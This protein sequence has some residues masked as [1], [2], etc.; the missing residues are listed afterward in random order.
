MKTKKKQSLTMMQKMMLWFM[1][2]ILLPSCI[3]SAV[4]YQALT[5][6]AYELLVEENNAVM[7]IARESIHRSANSVES[8]VENISL[9]QELRRLLTDSRQTTYQRIA[10]ILYDVENTISRAKLMLSGLDARFT[11]FFADEQI[12][13]AYWTYLK[14]E[15]LED[16]PNYQHFLQMNTSSGWGGIGKLYPEETIIRETDNPTRLCYYQKILGTQG[17]C[18]G[19]VQCGISPEKI[20]LPLEIKD[21]SVFYVVQDGQVIYQADGV[22]PLP[23]EYRAE[24]TRQVIN[25]QL[26]LTRSLEGMGMQLVMRLDYG[27]LHSQALASGLVP[28]L[29]ALGS[30]ALLLIATCTFLHSIQK[31]L[32]QAVNFAQRAKEG[33]LEIA[34]P[35]PGED[36][37]GR[38]I[39][40]FNTLLERLQENS[41]R[42]IDHERKE[43]YA[44][45]LALQYQMNPHFLFNSL[46][47]IQLSAELGV[48]REQLSEAVLLLGKL[49]RNNLQGNA[50]TTLEEEVRCAQDYVR[51]MNMRKQDLVQLKLELD[52]LPPGLPVMRFLFQPL[53]ENAIQHGMEPG[54]PLQITIRGQQTGERVHLSV[55]NDG[56][57]I[58]LDKQALLQE[59]IRH[60]PDGRGIGLANLSARLRLLY[61]SDAEMTFTSAAERTRI[62]LYFPPQ[63][64]EQAGRDGHGGKDE[65]PCDC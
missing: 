32:D 39:D 41:N 18:V 43:K 37:I 53:C 29:T 38:L 62:D 1:L 51:L 22:Q 36:E 59:Q 60:T 19:V 61:G 56:A 28:F 64:G 8:I 34:F 15:R 12:P 7:N 23:A 55:E 5:D 16:M 24:E 65:T 4:L 46:N 3:L 21:E 45:R 27:S 40:A 25:R 17:E 6:R 9:D 2:I 54:M 63:A 13:E 44:M 11:L 48:E 49:L 35:N 52:T 10:T 26:Y 47:W 58:P 50:M 57:M 30:G 14:L 20:F 31:R 33:S 42:M